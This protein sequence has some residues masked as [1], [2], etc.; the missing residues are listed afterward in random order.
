MDRYFTIRFP[1][2]Y[3]RNKTRRVMLL[4]IVAVWA[5]SAAVSSPVFVLGVVNKE[6]VLSNGVCAPNNASFK[7][8][9]SVFAFYIPFLIMIITYA[10]TMR[11]LR[12]VLVNKKKY[13]RERSRKQTF[14][15][16]ASIINQ[17]AEIAQNI[18]RTSSSV[19][20]GTSQT[21][22]PTVNDRVQSS[23]NTSNFAATN[24]I[25]NNSI[26]KRSSYVTSPSSTT[27][28]TTSTTTTANP[29]LS[30]QRSHQINRN[31]SELDST[32]N[33]NY[34]HFSV[35]N[36][37][38]DNNENRLNPQNL[39]VRQQKLINKRRRRLHDLQKMSTMN[40][41]IV[42]PV[43]DFD[44]STLY[45]ITEISKSTSSAHEMSTLTGI[46]SE[47]NLITTSE[48]QKQSEALSNND[49]VI[50][51]SNTSTNLSAAGGTG[52][53]VT[54]TTTESTINMIPSVEE[55]QLSLTTD[56][57]SPSM[58]VIRENNLLRL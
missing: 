46:N 29:C 33:S 53:T 43:N 19:N 52:T 6:N 31:Q 14:F 23:P 56:V 39:T 54:V 32:Q 8:Y 42:L 4:K 27:I 38:F 21:I 20:Q 37:D 7:I 16:L 18:R 10:L 30:D 50:S 55:E 44:M 35:D 26:P 48:Q 12:N 15:P 2:R 49:E 34:G 5:I 17:Y 47:Q 3:G 45:E 41:C 40:S 13:N 36:I 22:G 9:G 11:S 57:H 1:F 28:P 58:F 25:N 24:K 51:L